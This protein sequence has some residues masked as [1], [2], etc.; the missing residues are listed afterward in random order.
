MDEPAE[1]LKDLAECGHS[2]YPYEL[3]RVDDV[4]PRFCDQEL[5][6]MLNLIYHIVSKK[7]AVVAMACSGERLLISV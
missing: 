4:L 7:L 1:D 5:L 3:R 6:E 2:Q